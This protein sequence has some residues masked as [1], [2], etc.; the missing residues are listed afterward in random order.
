[1]GVKEIETAVLDQEWKELI[2]SALEMGI[3]PEEIRYYLR[4]HPNVSFN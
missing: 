3:S 1:M 4:N 2:L